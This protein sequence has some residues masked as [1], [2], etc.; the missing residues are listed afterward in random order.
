MNLNLD[1]E[2]REAGHNPDAIGKSGSH[3][4]ALHKEVAFVDLMAQ[5][6]AEPTAP[7]AA[8]SG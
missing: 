4:G 1:I 5:Q 6:S 7:A 8:Q 2:S 3:W